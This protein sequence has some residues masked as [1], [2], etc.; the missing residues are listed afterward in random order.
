MDDEGRLYE[1]NARGV[2]ARAILEDELVVA[3]FADA[4]REIWEA[5]KSSP[6]RDADG[7]EKLRLMQEWLQKFRQSM[8]QHLL[9]GQMAAETLEQRRSMIDRMR[10]AVMPRSWID[11]D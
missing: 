3:F 1:E 5:W 4:E 6:L 10:S 9:T 8:Q 11:A 7:R 2:R